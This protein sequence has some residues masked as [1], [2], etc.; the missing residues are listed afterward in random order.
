MNRGRINATSSSKQ[1]DNYLSASVDALKLTAYSLDNMIRDNRSQHEIRDF[2]MNQTVAVKNTLLGD[3][4]GLYGYINGEFMDGSGWEPEDDYMATERPWYVD[5]RANSGSITLVDPYLDLYTGDVM[6][7]IVKTL[8]DAKSVVAIDVSMQNLQQITED[9]AKHDASYSEI[10]IS[11]RGQII[12]SSDKQGIGEDLAKERGSLGEEISKEINSSGENSFYLKHD[13][14]DYII[15]VMP[16][17]N[18]WTCISV[19]DATGEYSKLKIPLITVIISAALLIAVLVFFMITSDRKSNEARKMSMR[20]ERAIAANEAKSAFLSNM[21]HEIRTPINSILGM[22]EMILRECEDDDIIKYSQ[23]IES[24]GATL[25]SLVNDILDFSKIEAGKMDIIP[26]DYNIGSLINDLIN[27]VHTRADEKGLKFKADIDENIP[28]GLHGDEI[29]IKQVI[30]NLLT[31]AVKY[32]NKGKVKLSIGYEDIENDPDS[33]LIKVAVKDTGIGIKPEDIEKLF[34][35][36]ERIEEERNRNIEGTG[37]GLNIASMLL[38]MMGSELKVE[39]VYGE[40]S[41]FYFTMVQK[42]VDRTP[43]GDFGSSFSG[44]SRHNAKNEAKF[45][46]PSANILVVDD[47][48]MN[49]FVFKSLLKRTKVQ[50]DTANSGDIGITM[51]GK[52]KYDIIFLDYLMPEKNGIETLKEMRE[53]EKGMNHDTPVICLTANAISGARETYINAGFDNYLSKPIDSVRLEE[54][55]IEY[56]PA[57]KVSML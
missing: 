25:L 26:V 35:K 37:L 33:I 57:E 40:G 23:N 19:S 30:T 20:S 31:N 51:A 36:F 48:K 27:M 14:T 53:D 46:A 9:H 10:I 41:M 17:G 54:M 21:S 50:I 32:T 44:A 42:V 45:I 8:C 22:N 1:I 12:A 4:T 11:D 18:G 47:A 29:R 55:M 15:Y 13:S 52:K 39:S 34:I 6:I 7:S 28:A 3:T 5:A 2:L 24:S 38:G 43:V 16:L 56:M 49:L